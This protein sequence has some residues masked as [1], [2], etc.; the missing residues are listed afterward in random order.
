VNR[1]LFILLSAVLTSGGCAN[2]S[3][4][5]ME[6][7]VAAPAAP[8]TVTKK[9]REL[10]PA[11]GEDFDEWE[12][13]AN[14]KIHDPIEPVNRGFFWVNHQLYTYVGKPISSA[15]EF[16]FPQVV[17]RGIHNA[18]ENLKFPVR[19]VNH[20]LQGR[21]DRSAKETGK[22]VVNTTAGVGGVMKPSEKITALNDVPSAD[23]AQTFAKWGV[24]HGAY[25]VVPVIGPS[26]T[27]EVVG[28]AG[29]TVLNP[30]SWLGLLFA[31]APW[32]LGVT[33][34]STV[35]SIPDQMDQYDAITKDAIDPYI[36]ARTG[37]IQYRNAVKDR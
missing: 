14:V 17:R 10:T 1:W 18:Y 35:R 12:E 37:Y 21:F 13:S 22:F 8:I 26:S 19:F 34:P 15:Y 33:A 30:V 16:L 31:G 7:N 11:A 29:D 20:T 27:R 23:T 36:S 2:R 25:L 4:H 32:T 9:A 28:T 5:P 6:K 24:P 3:E